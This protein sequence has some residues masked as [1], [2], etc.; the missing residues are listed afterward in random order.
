[1]FDA[2]DHDRQAGKKPRFFKKKF[3]VFFRFLRFLVFL[4][5]VYKTGH[6]IPKKR[7]ML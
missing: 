7:N 3:L 1:V 4:Y 2:G 5:F 6:K